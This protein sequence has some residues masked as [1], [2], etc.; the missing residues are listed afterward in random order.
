MAQVV[1]E[2]MSSRII[3]NQGGNYTGSR[4][5]AVWNDTT[6]ITEPSMISLGTGGMPAYGDQFPGEELYASTWQMEPIEDSSNAWLVTWSYSPGDEVVVTGPP[7]RPQ[8]TPSE[9]GWSQRS[10]D[11]GGQFKDAWRSSPGLTLYSSSYN[12]T[13]DI[14]GQKIDCG[15]NPISVFVPQMRI[16]ISETVSSGSLTRRYSNI[17][18]AVGTRN[19]GSWKGESIG[20]VLYEG[21][22]ARRVGLRS[23]TLEHRFL[24][25]DW[26][27]AVQQPKLN[28]QRNVDTASV[29][30]F[31][32]AV[33]VRWIQP[34]PNVSDFNLLSENF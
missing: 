1:V 18:G 26:L 9:I 7:D 10:F 30:G 33:T 13:A 25:D 2:Q 20:T 8:A 23:Y 4:K 24:V 29:N 11:F 12:G 16:V 22:S 31:L 28:S 27:H 17:S 6:P 5:F 14:S 15:G 34:F 21:A 3:S 32:H 19:S